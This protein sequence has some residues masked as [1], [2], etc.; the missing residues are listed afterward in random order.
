MKNASFLIK[1]ASSNCN[2]RC[3]YCFYHDVSANREQADYGIMSETTMN[4]MINKVFDEMDEEG[5]VTFAFQGGEPTVAG[6]PYF[7]RFVNKVNQARKSVSIHYA[8]QT[9]GTLID[10]EWCEFFHEHNFLV[11][12][13]LDG[14]E[15]NTNLF[16][17]DA[18]GKGVY[19]KIMQGIKLLRKHHVD[20]NVLTVLSERL[21][22]HPEAL[23]NYFCSQKFDYIQLIPC[24]PSLSDDEIMNKEALTPQTYA[25][26]FKSFFDLWFTDVK[27]GKMMS[28]NQ[29]DNLLTM[30]KGYAPYQCGIL[31]HCSVQCVVEGDGSV[32]PCD[33]FVSEDKRC[34]NFKDSS[35]NEMLTSEA[36]QKFVNEEIKTREIC[37]NC[38]YKKICNGG[39]K[40]MN[41]CF[42]EEDFC[43]Y[44]QLL[45]HALNSLEEVAKRMN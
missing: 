16:R 15:S 26:F 7:K 17:Y 34:G 5:H 44:Q 13:S 24:L 37:L 14:Y 8:I 21:A 45:R 42:L 20:F 40:R 29:F 11:G 43:G 32:Y 19:F 39:C 12:V 30:I 31:G 28:V 2:L 9:N 23:Y 36:A 3:T 41:V 1:P 22:K 25:S 38:E 6:L 18:K 35:L 27:K 33:F 4:E 10:D